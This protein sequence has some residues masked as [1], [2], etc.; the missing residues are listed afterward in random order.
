M[1]MRRDHAHVLQQFN[2]VPSLV[3]PSF[4]DSLVA[5][6]AQQTPGL[7]SRALQSLGMGSGGAHDEEVSNEEVCAAVGLNYSPNSKPFA[8]SGGFAVIPMYGAL[9][10]R[11][12]YCSPWATGYGYIG[13]R[14]QAAVADP[15]VEAILFDVHSYGGMVAGNFELAEEIYAARGT[16]PIIAMV[17]SMCYSGAYSLSSAADKIIAAPSSGAGSIGVVTSHLSFEKAMEKYGLKMTFIHAGDRKVDG[18]PYHDLPE[19]VRA[20]FQASVDKSYAKF[21]GLVARNRSLDVDAVIAT[22]AGCFD[23][24]EALSLGLIDAIQ[25]PSEAL[26]ALRKGLD[27]S[28]TLSHLGENEMTEKTE[29]TGGEGNASTIDTTAAV[30]TAQKAERDRINAIMSCNEAK[31]RQKLANHFALNTGMSVDD[32]KAALLASAVEPA[33]KAASSGFAAA[34]DGSDHPNVGDGG[35]GGGA[36]EM[37]AGERIIAARKALSGS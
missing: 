36:A 27:G 17:D 4:A 22:Q 37:S 7:L 14:F 6:A 33:P 8:F 35:A 24:E 30:A 3:E 18:N 1:T 5:M 23:A 26:A 13:A 15:D 31:D 25:T 11:D 2:N 19:D 16:K 34:M 21:T 12:S 20:R 28:T 10:H 9:I 32:A 29:K